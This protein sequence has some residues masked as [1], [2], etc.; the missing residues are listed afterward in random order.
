MRTQEQSDS[1]TEKLVARSWRSGY[2][3]F[4]KDRISVSHDEK[5]RRWMGLILHN[6]LRAF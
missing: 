2:G 4:V 6:I 3:E 5:L 1:Q